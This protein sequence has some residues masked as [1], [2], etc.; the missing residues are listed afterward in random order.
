MH[1]LLSW[2][3]PLH[4]YDAFFSVFLFF[5]FFFIFFFLYINFIITK[6]SLQSHF[7]FYTYIIVFLIDLL[8]IFILCVDC[9]KVS[10]WLCLLLRLVLTD[11][12]CCVVVVLV[13]VVVG[14]VDCL[15]V[16]LFAVVVCL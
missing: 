14:R 13:V 4:L 3:W 6:T 5:C 16:C 7:F 12:C 15:F 11:A 10:L 2:L 9:P 8:F 1:R